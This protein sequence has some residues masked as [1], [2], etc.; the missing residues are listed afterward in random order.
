VREGGRPPGTGLPFLDW[1]DRLYRPLADHLGPV[2]VA[3]AAGAVFF[4]LF[5]LFAVWVLARAMLRRG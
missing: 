2:G 5:A 1:T 4:V 3:V